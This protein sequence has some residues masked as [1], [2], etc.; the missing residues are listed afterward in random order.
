ME[1]LWDAVVANGSQDLAVA[2]KIQGEWLTKEMLAIAY[3]GAVRSVETASS[4]DWRS[5]GGAVIQALRRALVLELVASLN[6]VEWQI[7]PWL[8][9]AKGSYAVGDDGSEAG[10]GFFNRVAATE[11]DETVKGEI[12]RAGAATHRTAREAAAALI[13]RVKVI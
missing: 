4:S 5:H 2:C 11:T 3:F 10:R 7:G 13:K 12:E 6:E 8:D 1:R 9:G